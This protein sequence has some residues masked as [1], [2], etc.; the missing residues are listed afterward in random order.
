MQSRRQFLAASGAAAG[1]LLTP[2]WAADKATKPNDKM[3]LAFV[4]L[5]WRGGQLLDAFSKFKDVEVVALSD[6]DE[7]RLGKVGEKFPKAIREVDMRKVIDRPDV[8]AVIVATPNHW[9]CLAAIRACQAGKDVYCEKPLGHNLWEQ[10]Q[11]IKAARAGERIVQVGTQQRSSPLQAQARKLL[12]DDQAIG[13]LSHVVVSRIGERKPIGQRNRPLVAP[14][15]VDYDL[16]VGP[17]LDQPLYRNEF[18]YDWHWDWNTGNGEMGNWGVHVLDDVL[19][20]ALA[21][22][23]GY[24]SAVHSAAVR[25]G[26][27]DAGNTP[28]IQVAWYENNTLPV[29]MIMSNVV[30]AGAL[31]QATDFIG[32]DTGYTVF[33]EGG[34]F[35]GS[36]GR[37]RAIDN[38]GKVI[39]EKGGS[40]G[41]GIHQRNFL[42]AVL[43]RDRSTLN[44]EVETGHISTAWCHL[45][46]IA[47]LE[48]EVVGKT[49]TPT[50][51]E[52]WQRLQDGYE[53]QVTGVGVY[54]PPAPA[55][56]IEV[57]PKTG[58]VKQ[59]ESEQAQQLV[60]RAYR[61]EK[62]KREF[63]V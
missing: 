43:S 18:H 5:G 45:A 30:P 49:H 6:A 48:G 58:Q 3:G 27:R 29:Q 36:R 55:G 1:M 37:W 54:N 10:E 24:P 7:E 61:S 16:W 2:A 46:S 41:D 4:G 12:H 59:V 40:A 57:D 39:A 21:D 22:K 32:F 34:K 47:A 25:A 8:D 11:L 15:T 50:S 17:A 56:S 63:E 19:N 35:C 23:A 53:E 33:G 28:N 60:R 38:D 51:N 62:W 31:K 9:H 44:A 26:W 13:K 20:V 52:A 14:S 42:D